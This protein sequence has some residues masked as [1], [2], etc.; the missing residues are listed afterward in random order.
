MGHVPKGGARRKICAAMSAQDVVTVVAV[1]THNAGYLDGLREGCRRAGLP[2]QVLGWGQQWKGFGWRTRLVRDWL[3][4]QPRDAL[5]VHVDAFD[6]LA[7]LPSAEALVSRYVWHGRSLLLSV[8]GAPA[9]GLHDGA[10]EAVFGGVAD[11]SGMLVRGASA[12]GRRVVLNGGAFMGTAGALLQLYA[13][14]DAVSG[15]GAIENECDDQKTLNAA[16]NAFADWFARHAAVDVRGLVFANLLCGVS[17]A[18]PS[19]AT[20]ALDAHA[21]RGVVLRGTE[22]TPCFVHGAGNC[23]LD[24]VAAAAALPR[25]QGNRPQAEYLLRA[26][27]AYAPYIGSEVRAVLGT[28]LLLAALAVAIGLMLRARRKL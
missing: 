22:T 11:P 3:R 9:A 8:D 17:D 16:A 1:A 24:A 27:K 6:V 2:L 26:S 15:G 28:A 23:N 18:P 20:V 12:H 10:H 19:D 4:T 14:M 5:V 13:R 25:G 21:T 7:T